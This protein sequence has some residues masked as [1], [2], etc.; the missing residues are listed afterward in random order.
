MIK[1][2]NIKAFFTQFS[3]SAFLWVLC[4]LGLSQVA[5][6]KN[7][8]SEIKERGRIVL[9]TNAEFEPFEYK[10]GSET[11]GI[12]I[13]IAKEIA[14]RMGVE[15]EIKDVSF[16][17]CEDEPPYIEFWETYDV[18]KRAFYFDELVYTEERPSSSDIIFHV[19]EN[20]IPK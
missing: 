8:V 14:K 18:Y 4:F 15:I 11:V 16:D 3:V 1:I 10:E 19:P 5:F 2:K 13:D 9:V 17:V 6:A 12:D 7:E 20:V